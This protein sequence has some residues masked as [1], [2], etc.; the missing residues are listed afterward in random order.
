MQYIIGKGNNKM[1]LV[2]N[3]EVNNNEVIKSLDTKLVTLSDKYKLVETK[4]IAD[5]FKAMGFIVDD[6]TETKVRKASKKGFNRLL[7]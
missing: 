3:V 6:Y 1:Q 4:K 5:K 7:I 2:Q